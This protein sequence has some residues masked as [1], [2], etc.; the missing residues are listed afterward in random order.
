MIVWM[1][2]EVLVERGAALLADF[3]RACESTNESAEVTGGRVH[4]KGEGGKENERSGVCW[5]R[6]SESWP[7]SSS[8]WY[9]GLPDTRSL[10]L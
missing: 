7:S 9:G 6:V 1:Q 3:L 5:V 4:V 2:S 8:S 10:H